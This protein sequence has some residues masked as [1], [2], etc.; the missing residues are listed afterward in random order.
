MPTPSKI[1]ALLPDE[2]RAQL[3]VKIKANGFGG[4]RDLAAWLQGEGYE[5]SKS[6]VHSHGQKLQAQIKKIRAATEQADYLRTM[7]P[8]DDG[9]MTDGILRTYTAE[10]FEYMQDFSLEGSKVDPVKLGRVIKDIAHASISQ[11]KLQNEMRAEMAARASAAVENGEWK[12]EAME[13]AKRIMGF[14]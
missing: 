4:Y 3:N 5:I 13:E 10:I 14:G 1:D 9:A 12:A 7:F 8:D 2:V 6:A 11:K